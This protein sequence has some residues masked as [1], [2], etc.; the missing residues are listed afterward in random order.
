MD[1]VAKSRSKKRKGARRDVWEHVK[2]MV[3]EIE[4]VLCLALH[5]ISKEIAFH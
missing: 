4:V 5:F 1:V 2:E 3:K